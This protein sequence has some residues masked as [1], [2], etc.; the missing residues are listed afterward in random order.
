MSITSQGFK[1]LWAQRCL[2]QNAPEGANGY[3]AMP[4]HDGGADTHGRLLDKLDMTAS[5][6]HFR[7]ARCF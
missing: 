3:L 1:F 2:S 4:R 6:A 7:K 5:L